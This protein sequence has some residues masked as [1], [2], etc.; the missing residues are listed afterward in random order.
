MAV[1]SGF[2]GLKDANR[3]L[4]ALP[5]TAKSGVQQVVDTTS[6]RVASRAQAT[7][8]RR[9][10]LLASR[11]KWQSRPRTLA[12]VVGVEKDAFYWKFVEYGTVHM[13]AHPF[14]RPAAA[15]EESRHQRELVSA[16]EKANTQMERSVGS[17]SSRLL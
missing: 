16:L 4:R 11:I 1:T 2:I 13:E 17:A 9:T 6:Y 15:S 3:A 10:G 7:V 8:R 12:A 14:L 5:A